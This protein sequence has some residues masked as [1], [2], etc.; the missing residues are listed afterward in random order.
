MTTNDMAD[1]PLSGWRILVTRPQAQAVVWQ[2]R[3]QTAGARC[4][5]VPLMAIEPV[6]SAA[7]QQAIKNC[8]MELDAYQHVILVSQNAVRYGVEWIDA[9]WPQLPLGVN[10]YA[11]GAA[12][13]RQLRS[14]DFP[15]IADESSSAPM[16]SEALLALP[17]LQQVHNDRVL[18]CRGKGGRPL[19]A[20]V[21]EERGAR[22]DYCELY[23]RVFPSAASQQVG[24]LGWGRENDLVALHSG[25]ALE[26]WQQ[27]IDS[28]DKPQWRQLP[29]VVPGQRVAD[30]AADLGFSQV[31]VS[32]NASDDSMLAALVDAV[33]HG[34]LHN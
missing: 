13:A 2:E 3:L 10:F 20:E 17:E 21:L 29:M 15:V 28:L 16:N 32:I 5:Q 23:E 9:Y 34:R 6:T 1:Q 18:I 14:A 33:S 22:V 27:V 31:I 26:N 30:L 7:E 25:E 8:V 12:T 19:L 11:V 24:E 4:A